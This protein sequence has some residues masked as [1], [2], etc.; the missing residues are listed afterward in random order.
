MQVDVNELK[1]IKDN[2]PNGMYSIIA[3]RL[4]KRGVEATRF[5]VAKEATSI[6]N[7]DADYNA[8]IISELREVFTLL[9]GLS[10]QK[11]IA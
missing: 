5:T 2:T 1:F 3:E 8:E 4:R 7:D 9:T 11:S 6:K 10:Y